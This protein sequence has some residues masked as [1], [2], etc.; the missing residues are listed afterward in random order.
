MDAKRTLATIFYP[1]KF[2]KLYSDSKKKIK[3]HTSKKLILN[4]L[5]IFTKIQII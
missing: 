3:K 1:K 5:I 2:M 4:V